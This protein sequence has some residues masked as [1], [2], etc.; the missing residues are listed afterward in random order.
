MNEGNI[1]KSKLFI[2]LAVFAVVFG[3]FSQSFAQSE[4]TGGRG[5]GVKTNPA[6]SPKIPESP[7][8]TLSVGSSET[9]HFDFD[10]GSAEGWLAYPASRWSVSNGVLKFAG[11]GVD[12]IR[13][14]FFDADFWDATIEV[15]A[16]QFQGATS[17]YLPAFGIAARSDNS[18]ENFYQFVVTVD[19]YY[20]I[21]LFEDGDW[22]SIVDWGPTNLLDDSPGEWNT[23]KVEASGSVLAFYINGKL[24]ETISDFG[25]SSGKFGVVAY[26]GDDPS[27]P[28]LVEFDNVSIVSNDIGD[29][30]Y[31]YY[32]PYFLA[33]SANGTGVALKNMNST[34][35]AKTST[36]VYDSRGD[37]I[38]VRDR[39]IAPKG[40]AVFLVAQGAGE[41]G[42][43]KVKS[44]RKLAG[45]CFVSTAANPDFMMDIMLISELS[46]ILHVPHVA[47]NNRWDTTLFV[48]NP[49]DSAIAVT[50][51]YVD[52][53]GKK[54]YSVQRNASANG[55]VKID[56]RT[57]L[58]GATVG[59]G[60]VE[61]TGTGPVAGFALYT[62]IK[63]GNLNY[64]GIAAM[65]P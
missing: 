59:A 14:A 54:L 6:P 21:G 28:V 38:D 34:Q 16:R 7:L 31:Q 26:E 4:N 3:L 20:A 15:D 62:D 8:Q 17:A 37:I 60:S 43:I 33:D 49:K 55:S 39:T 44:D 10:D 51:N 36:V 1:G 25:F 58:G 5:R 45:L 48:C 61:V 23:L 2:L 63:S 47:Q 29:A 46:N 27:S 9:Y 22:T 32:L 64:A 41:E 42:W 30:K 53:A 56:L 50:F 11:N 12:D 52:Q 57:I 40:Q 24:A 19:G 65:T 35:S 18:A 13:Y